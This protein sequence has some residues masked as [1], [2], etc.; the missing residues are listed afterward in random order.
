MAKQVAQLDR[1]R[2]RAI[3]KSGSSK[4]FSDQKRDND[5]AVKEIL[6][7]AQLDQ[8]NLL[9]APRPAPSEAPT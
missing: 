7:Q 1:A 9:T 5:A 3:A 2:E 6:T 8:W 4:S